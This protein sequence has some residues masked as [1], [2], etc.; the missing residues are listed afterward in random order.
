MQLR[1]DD[2]Q[3]M[4]GLDLGLTSPQISSWRKTARAAY[5][6]FARLPP[7]RL[8]WLTVL[9]TPF[10]HSLNEP[11]PLF[12]PHIAELRHKMIS[13]CKR[14]LSGVRVR[15]VFELDLLH[16]RQ[17]SPGGH[18]ESFFLSRGVDPTILPVDARLCLPHIHAVVDLSKHPGNVFRSQMAMEFT[19]PWRVVLRPLHEDK[20]V[21]QNLSALASYSTKLKA[22]Y[23]DWHPDRPTKFG[24]SVTSCA[25]LSPTPFR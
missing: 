8:G 15:G 24:P 4:L 6:T 5:L 11:V 3:L 14:K 22:A 19:G 13:R 12:G 2:E 18:K 9:G 10:V 7:A 1:P 20:T 25:R 21:T 23:S 17:I 16:R